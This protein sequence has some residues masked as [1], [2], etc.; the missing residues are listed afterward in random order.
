MKT[1]GFQTFLL[2]TDAEHRG[3]LLIK[4]APLKRSF[5]MNIILISANQKMRIFEL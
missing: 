4:K 2:T 5:F 3:I 1:L